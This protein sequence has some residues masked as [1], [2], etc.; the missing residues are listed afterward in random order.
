MDNTREI[1]VTGCIDCPYAKVYAPVCMSELHPMTKTV[2]R[3]WS[4]VF[5]DCPLKEQPITIILNK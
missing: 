5:A 3:E 1:T 4:D 2:L